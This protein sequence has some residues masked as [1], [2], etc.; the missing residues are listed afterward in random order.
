M[1]IILLVFSYYDIEKMTTL[2]LISQIRGYV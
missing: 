1:N 2:C